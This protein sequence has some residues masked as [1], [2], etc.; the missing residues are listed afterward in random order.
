MA[1]HRAESAPS[2]LCIHLVPEFGD[3]SADF[4]VLLD[5]HLPMNLSLHF[6]LL[7]GH[8]VIIDEHVVVKGT[9]HSTI[10]ILSY[11]MLLVN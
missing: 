11:L 6:Y 4:F 7:L 3:L 2:H 10:L 1:S 5:K 9:V 8:C